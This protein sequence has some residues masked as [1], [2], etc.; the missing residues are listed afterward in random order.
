MDF[1]TIRRCKPFVGRILGGGGEGVL[2]AFQGF[3]DG[4][5]YVNVDIVFWVVTIDGQSSVLAAIWV[6]GDGV[7]ISECINEVV[8]V[9]GGE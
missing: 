6:N 4:V 8:G 2:E 5:R 7:V 1:G 9:V 3:A